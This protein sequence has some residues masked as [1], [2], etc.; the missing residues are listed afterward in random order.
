MDEL[1]IALPAFA[2]G[3]D[4]LVGGGEAA[5]PRAGL[6]W[7]D[8]PARRLLDTGPPRRRCDRDAG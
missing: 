5:R 6:D 2:P 8:A 1:P 7:L 4:W 3:G